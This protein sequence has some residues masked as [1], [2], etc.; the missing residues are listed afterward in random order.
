MGI[1]DWKIYAGGIKAK[2]LLSI[3]PREGGSV[4]LEMG[5]EE[6]EACGLSVSKIFNHFSIWSSIANPPCPRNKLHFLPQP[7]TQNLPLFFSHVTKF[8]R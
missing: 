1:D 4:S 7:F 5:E 8:S 6:E 3:V 2:E